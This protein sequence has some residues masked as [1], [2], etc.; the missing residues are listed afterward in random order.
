MRAKFTTLLLIISFSSLW[1]QNILLENMG[2]PTANTAI[3]S[4]T[5][6]N[7]TT[8][9][10]SNGGQ[11]N[12][13][14]VRVTNPSSSYAT[15]SGGGNVFFS[16]SAGAY[17]FSIEGINASNYTSIVIQYGYRK[18]AA[19]VHATFSVDY[20]NG[21]T[22]VTLANTSS[23]LFNE[24]ATAGTGWYQAKSL[25]LSSDAQI[26]GLKIR[27]VKTGTTSIR[28]DDV[29]LIGTE[30]APTLKTTTV[31]NVTSTSA[32]FAGNVT[33]TGGSE[34]IATGTVYSAT[35]GNPNPTF[36]GSGVVTISSSSPNANTGS[37]TN[38]SGTVLLPNIQ[39]SYA[40]YATKSTGLTGYGSVYTFYTLAATPT[41]PTVNSP[42]G[43]SLHV[44]IGNDTNSVITTYAIYETST[45]TYVQTNGTLG[46]TAVYQSATAWGTKTVTGLVPTT[47]YT[48]KTFAKNGDGYV[49][50]AS[51]SAN[52]TTLVVPTITTSGTLSALTTVYGTVSSYTSFTV[53]ASNLTDNLII[54]APTGFEISKTVGG[55]TGYAFSQTLNPSSGTIN[56]TTIYVRLSGNAYGIYSGNVTVTSSNDGL[57][58]NVPTIASSVT[59]LGL[60]ISGITVLNK[61][62]DG[63]TNAQLSGSGIL[64]GLL[65]SDSATVTLV[66]SGATATFADALV[67][68]GKTITIVGY[69]LN[70]ASSA[71]YSLEQPTG[72][73]ADITA[74]M[75]SDV[76]LNSSS[77]T[78]NNDTI[79]YQLFQG[80]V[81]SNSTSGING[82]TGV[83]GFYVRDGGASLSD[84][85]TLP[86]E[87]TAI[88]F[89][90]ANPD[91]ILSARLFS[92]NTP[93]GQAVLVNGSSTITFT[94][95]SNEIVAPDNDK[96]AINLR[97]TFKPNVIDNQQMQFTIASVTAKAT[98]SRFAAVNGGGAASKITGDINK[99]TVIADRLVFE[100]QPTSGLFEGTVIS[101][102]PTVIAKDSFGSIDLDQMNTVSLT[103]SGPLS[104]TP[105]VPSSF[106]N[107]VYTFNSI[108]PISGGTGFFLTAIYQG[109]IS[110]ISNSFAVNS[111]LIPT[112]TQVDPI[113]AG[114][115][116]SPLPIQSNNGITGSWSPALN[117]LATTT[118]T[119]TP[120]S[121]QNATT[122]TLTITVNPQVTP[123]FT[124]IS[125]IFSGGTLLPLPTTSNNGISGTWLPSLNNTVTTTYTF[126]PYA[127]ICATTASLTIT[128]YPGNIT[129]TFNPIAPICS[130]GAL[131][132]LP[133]TS[134][135]GITGTWTPA[136]NNTVTTTYTFTPD[137]SQGAV[138]TTLTILVNSTVVT[139]NNVPPTER[140]TIL[141][142]LPT[143]S[144]EGITGTWSPALNNLATTTYTFTPSAPC[145]SIYQLTIIITEPDNSGGDPNNT[146]GDPNS[147][148]ISSTPSY[149]DTQGKLEVSNSGQAVYTLPIALPP[150]ISSVGP[151]INLVY[152]SGQND[153]IAGQGW[154]INSISCIKRVASRFDIDGFKDGVDFDTNDKLVL[155]GQRL[156]V[157]SS[158]NYWADGSLYETEV[159]SNNKIQL[160]GSGTNM[161]FIVTSP[162]GSRSW[163]GNYGGMNATDLS[164]YY[165]VRFE[166]VEGNFILYNYSKPLNKGLCIDTIQFSANIN[167]NSTP[168]NYIKFN[169][170]A[171]AK[172]EKAYFKG[173]LVEKSE[174]LK[175]IKVYTN[176]NLFKE[177]R[178][179][180][181]TDSQLGY[182][183]VAKIQEF[184]SAGEGA[185]PIA[186]EYNSTEDVVNE[187][188]KIYAD[189]YAV[190][191]TPELTGDFD[192]DGKLDIVTSDKMYLK[193]FLN[194]AI[195]PVILPLIQGKKIIATTLKNNK[196]NQSQ[197]IIGAKLNINSVVFKYYDY[198]QDTNTVVQEYTKTI[199]MDNS[200][201][202][203]NECEG[204]S[205]ANA[206]FCDNS[207][208][209][210]VNYY[211]GDF[212]GDGITE[213]IVATYYES[214]D[215]G[216]DPTKCVSLR[217]SENNSEETCQC[218]LKH[219]TISTVPTQLLMVNLDNN[220]STTVGSP[221]VAILNGLG[222]SRN[223]DD[224]VM[225][226]D[227][228]SD[229]KSDILF[230]KADKSYKVYS[231]NQLTVSPWVEV[232]VLGQG[233][234]DS[235]KAGK[236]FLLGDYN[237][238]GKPD[239]MIPQADGDC[240]PRP[241][242][243]TINSSGQVVIISPAIECPN[244]NKWDVYY[245]NPNPS[246]GQFFTKETHTMSDY[247]KQTG[248]D[249]FSYY[250]LD[251][252][253]DGKSD[254]VKAAVGLYFTGSFWDS[255][256]IDSRWKIY[257]YVNNLGNNANG[258]QDF[259]NAYSQTDGHNNDDNSV[260]IVLV[261]DLKY[262]GLS[263]DMLV[264]RFHRGNSFAKRI[265]YIDFVKNVTYENS[266]KKVT[267]S[268]GGIVDEISYAPMESSG[269][270]GGLGVAS[271]FYSS[272]NS[273]NYPAI[274]IKQAF[275]NKLVSKLK[276]IS[277]GITRTQEFKYNGYIV[278]L[279][280][281]GAIGFKKV[282]RCAWYN[283]PSDKKT[284]SVTELDPLLRGATKVAYTLLPNATD[285]SFPTN[286]STGLMSKT[287]NV[288]NSPAPNVFPY[289]I[290]L[291]NQK[292]TDYITGIVKETVY[293]SYNSENLPISVTNNNYVGTTLQGTTTTVTEYDPSSFGSGSDYYIGRPHKTTTT[294]TAYQDTKKTSETYT[295]LNGNISETDK[296]VYQSD[297]TVDPVTMVEK[298]TYYPNGLL[299]DKEI[300]ATGTTVGINDVTP[301]KVSYTYDPTNR[302]ISTTTDAEL[303]V[304]T[305]M[306]FHPL[307]G[308]ALVTKD[309]FNQTIT[310]VYDNWGKLINTTDNSLSLKTNYTYTRANNIYT[311]T[312]T[313][314]TSGGLS[315]GSSSVVDQDVLAREVRKGSKNLNG[316]WTFV[317]TEYDNYGRKLRTSEPYF[318][319]S[320]PSQWTV[321]AYDDYSR[322]IRTTSFTG[323]IV[324]T[325]YNGLTVV[326][327]D[328]VMS[329]SKTFD[330]NGQT[331][332][333]TDTPGGTINYTYD[334]DGN[335]LESN[336]GGIKT[337]MT[338]DNWGRKLTLVDSSSGTY[339]YSY[340]AYG[341][342]KTEGAPKGVTTYTYDG[343]SGRVLTKSIQGLTTADATNIVSTYN[344]NTTTKLLDSMTV[345]NPNDGDSAFAYTYD[346]QRRLYKT[347]E[348]QNLLPS[349]TAVFAKQ[350]TFDNFSRIDTETNTATAFGKTSSKVIKH[351]YSGNNGYF[352]GFKDNV[353]QNVLW[354]TNSIN[355]RNQLTNAVMGNGISVINTYD[356]YGYSFS[357]KYLLNST[358]IILTLNNEFDPI[359]GNL[360]SRFNSQFD[361]K[362]KF[363]YDALD[364][365]VT[366]EGTSSNLM[367][368][369]FNTTT[370]GFTFSG[371]SSQGSVS[372]VTSKL[373]VVLKHSVASANRALNINAAAGDKFRIRGDISGL[374][375]L[376]GTVT[377]L[378]MVETDLDDG[379]SYNEFTIMELSDNGAFDFEYTVSDNFLNVKLSLKFVAEGQDNGGSDP[380][381]IIEENPDGTI[382]TVP[383]YT[384]ATFYLDNLKI[385]SIAINRQDYDER[386]RIVNNNV[387][388][389]GYDSTHPYQNNSIVMTPEAKTYYADR[390]LQD[391]A[392]NA[393]KAPVKIEEQGIDLIN[394]GYNAFQERSV[395]YYGNTSAD[396][397]SKP[398]RKYYSADGSMEIKATFAASDT[399]TPVAVEFMTYLGGDAY[400][401]AVVLKSDGTTQ[402]YFYLHRDYQG[403][404][405]AIT[406]AAAAVVEKRLFD[407]WGGI[408]KVQDGAGNAL[409][410][411]TFFDRGYTGHEHLQSVGLI[412]MNARLY[413]PKLHRFLE[414]DNYIQDPY[415][416]QNYNR[417]GYCVN[418]PL[419]YTD[420]TG[421]MFENIASFV[422]CIPVLGSVFASLLMHQSI[423]WGRVAV[424][425]IVTGIS[426]AVSY[427]IGSACENI[428]RFS[429]KAAVSALA[430]GAFQGGLA[431]A[432]GGKFWAGFASGALSS[433][434]ASVW[435]GGTT[436]TEGFSAEN[437]W[438]WGPKTIVHEGLGAGT[439][440][441]GTLAFS[442][443]MGGAGSALAGGNF[444]QGATTGLIV[445]GFND[446]MHDDNGYD[447]NGK[448]IN[449]N[450]GNTT[451][452]LY[453]SNGKIISSTSV[454]YI[455]SISQG[456]YRELGGLRGYGFRGD[457][458]AT[459]AANQDNTIFELFAGGK[460]VKNGLSY[461]GE[462]F[463]ALK[464]P[465]ARYAGAY[466]K[467]FAPWLNR[468]RYFRLGIS[469]TRGNQ[470]FRLTFGNKWKHIFD[471]DL[472]KIP[473]IK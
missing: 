142:P 154:D 467:E 174:L 190:V 61:V 132:P 167:G 41:V 224:K 29:K 77:A 166:D 352:T 243:T 434:A 235:Y 180:H 157:K 359:L 13:A 268:N 257:T 122:T 278:Q 27:F 417:Y 220:A 286:L 158:S 55:A 51:P 37:F 66:T 65:A 395:M 429:T 262:K 197:T 229:G 18:E 251:I 253:K 14:D 35:S 318:D 442:A 208:K 116:L 71:N 53:G 231:F 256:D 449:N 178:L 306:S 428:A 323:K 408:V 267:Q 354:K 391:I 263:S 240:H 47:T 383:S 114:G 198:H 160:I 33:A 330:A 319:S 341:E 468:G 280:G 45:G 276:N 223:T 200:A 416:T 193:T 117:N 411:L 123:S 38:S 195:P 287:E 438:A 54:T 246:G 380:E 255:T 139:F 104:T 225:V 25:S 421:N 5:F 454:E 184:N 420:V 379:I 108:T 138:S 342:I 324:N 344:Y 312:V 343:L 266:L 432:T 109:L 398:Y 394:F 140:G 162:D 353:T 457:A 357:N 378:V 260:P 204:Y 293:N 36:G 76:V 16:S 165:I 81:L 102:S 87:L 254:V 205:D 458:M 48:F 110:A 320:S 401:A 422:S 290:L 296:N 274:E 106:S 215:Y 89:N 221:G 43:T 397:L 177:Y 187:T 125:P 75:S 111:L 228:N 281:V 82:C 435:G 4:N 17:G 218:S 216:I 384:N 30:T 175:K 219:E 130:G 226:G 329:K 292:S 171:A 126:T 289:A 446:L 460:V 437:N 297:G 307:Y 473:K 336:Y 412:N 214:Y 182:Q 42:S 413:D 300:S 472:G 313:K 21:N 303:L 298:M 186:F 189:N 459:G 338:Y 464:A 440:A 403:S 424:D 311:T 470:V 455:G 151:T 436:E 242:I 191:D 340:N 173:V 328:S 118:Y 69:S 248:D 366:W 305:N 145:A 211:E 90:V 258:S 272:N 448:Q 70:G 64:N 285:F 62:C 179:T 407:P 44:A 213:V 273:V 279:D 124:P 207:K 230:V 299:K 57:M 26:N 406:N 129:P 96:I 143:T 56:T 374:T 181:S 164:A 451:D 136:L 333:T 288:F 86:T 161:Y 250:V 259:I 348:T 73:T 252:N 301:R 72:L 270:N 331:T 362:E 92:S 382:T 100:Q 392:Y 404:I 427:G 68:A 339:T 249:Y 28:I 217:T 9:S 375:L 291:Q 31:D 148:G 347:E 133:T 381:Y 390:P 188:T 8:L 10:Y 2:T 400:T 172:T 277:L 168:L 194:A 388:Q 385:D 332:T 389:Y 59:K 415:N 97:V 462:G 222:L 63:T 11:V 350:L 325:T 453:D 355:A 103:S 1:A 423:N 24:A 99:V 363:T 241:A 310:N 101:P 50:A 425:A 238:D 79:N 159:Q 147:T 304:S 196:L 12:S 321:Y 244:L 49:T 269:V 135:N 6:Q 441:I 113:C 121:S 309:P 465:M 144:L 351:T 430:H 80:T 358:S 439:G 317:K 206:N 88:T 23:A 271:D 115:V 183:R 112:F 74:N 150:S 58:V 15:A 364:H 369:P 107:G 370:D 386:G 34:I 452:Y 372:N 20:W 19:S 461:L 419:K 275:G 282:A 456:E 39:Y 466:I 410:Q 315:D 302:F 368:L 84:A 176:G 141:N 134:T 367:T 233:V 387:G 67:G 156:L 91:N 192:G 234:L 426:I 155:D 447:K 128:V 361:V 185:N 201:S 152:S 327:A 393:F 346:S 209:K 247:F 431:A 371:T 94:G 93:L 308:T 83:M 212:N 463:N 137:S 239:I 210:Y 202:C 95:L 169:Y 365:L 105:I 345:S 334:A 232:E 265:T 314:T 98:G 409:P 237:G 335:L 376:N 127:G 227:Y 316:T 264:I 337:T 443:V 52:G 261:A 146:A 119:F 396:K 444:W 3:T 414:A 471:I 236:P 131:A 78:S 199:P 322:P 46:A 245:S 360:K 399:T 163:Y 32:F 283:N 284:W 60:T 418:N 40:A 445:A 22:W 356:A 405:L 170:T 85:D 402:N 149:H 7:S 377:R 295:Y 120:N 153:G 349:G 450:G 433:I 294:T 373:K 203:S 326:V 469:H